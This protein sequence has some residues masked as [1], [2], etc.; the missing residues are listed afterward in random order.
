MPIYS[1]S[2]VN[3][4]IVEKILTIAERT[5]PGPCP[6]CGRILE[7][8]YLSRAEERAQRFEP[9]VYFE[10]P[11]GRFSFPGR[12]DAKCPEGFETK[13]VCTFREYEQFSRKVNQIERGKIERQVEAE[14]EWL[15][16]QEAT[17]R[18]DLRS[19]MEHMSPAWRAF[20]RRAMEASNNNPNRPKVRDPNFYVEV[21]E[22]DQSNR[23]SFVDE[24]NG[25]RRRNG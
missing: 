15:E 5:N 16:H 25:W 22:H 9:I 1:F 18:R 24:R 19:A 10:S 13:R 3:E 23:E 14:Q 20:A 8:R 21:F 12:S 7:R 2:C 11:D 4:H 6:E 17:N